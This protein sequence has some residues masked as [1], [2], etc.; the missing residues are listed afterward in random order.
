[1]KRY[2][3]LGQWQEPVT[4]RFPGDQRQSKCG[5]LR[6]AWVEFQPMQRLAGVVGLGT[7]CVLWVMLGD[8]RNYPCGA[9][10]RKALHAWRAGL[11]DTLFPPGTWL[12]RVQHRVCCASAG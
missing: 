2:P 10:Y 4:A 7:A 1:M 8:P 11:R 9:A 12:M 6:A 5:D 3:G